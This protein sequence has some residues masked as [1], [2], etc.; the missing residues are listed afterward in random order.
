MA[1]E[2]VVITLTGVRA[3]GRH[4]VLES[5]R[6]EGQEFLVDLRLE[7]E[8]DLAADDLAGT[9][10][11]AEVAQKAVDHVSATPY[12]LIETLAGR[13]ADTVVSLERVQRV[14][15]T[16]HK[17]HAPIPVPFTDVAVT[18]IRSKS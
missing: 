8:V 17:P 15:V 3:T 18:V 16:V 5:E 6:R 14:E 1:D 7:T 12:D 2:P 9:V 4:G 10:N 13:I 11:Y